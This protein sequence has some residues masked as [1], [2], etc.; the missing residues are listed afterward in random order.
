MVRESLSQR[1]IG[2]I[3]LSRIVSRGSIAC[4]HRLFVVI[5]HGNDMRITSCALGFGSG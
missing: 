1:I 2:R 4:S 5:Y 3:P